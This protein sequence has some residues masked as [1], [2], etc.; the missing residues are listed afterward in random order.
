MP[1]PPQAWITPCP[2]PGEDAEEAIEDEAEQPTA[3]DVE[4]EAVEDAA[5]VEAEAVDEAAVVEAEAVEEAADVDAV[6]SAVAGAVVSREPSATDDGST[7]TIIWH[8]EPSAVADGRGSC[9]D[10]QLGMPP[11]PPTGSSNLSECACDRDSG[12]DQQRNGTVK[13]S[14]AA[15]STSSDVKW[16]DAMRQ[17]DDL[18]FDDPEENANAL[19]ETG[20][21]TNRAIKQLMIASINRSIAQTSRQKQ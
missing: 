18:G 10:P 9:L 16:E 8:D 14:P 15:N 6:E 17:L 1:V 7:G 3:A 20:G 4:A 13:P 5:D 19:K 2:Q 21:D 12:Y 11:E